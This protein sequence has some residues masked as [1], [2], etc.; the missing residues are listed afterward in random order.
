MGLRQRGSLSGSSEEQLK[1]YPGIKTK[2]GPTVAV[3]QGRELRSRA[4]RSDVH[5]Q[6]HQRHADGTVATG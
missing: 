3:V 4:R 5:A 6:S 1:T 2:R